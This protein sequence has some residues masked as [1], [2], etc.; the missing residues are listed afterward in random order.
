TGT[1]YS[2]PNPA[3]IGR[4]VDE[5]PSSVLAGHAWVGVQQGTICLSA[6]GK[7]PVFSGAAVI[8]MVSVGFCETRV[9]QQLL[10]ELPGYAVTLLLALALGAIG[11]LLLASRLKRQTFGLEPYEIAGLLEEREASLQGIH[12]GAIATD[13]D[14]IITLANDEGRRLLDLPADCVGRKISQ[15]LPQGRLL[16][17]LSGGLKDQDEV[18]LAGDRVLLASRRSIR[19]RG[20]EIGHVATLR[21]STEITGLARGLGVDSLTDALRAQ[22]HEFANRLHTIAG[23]VQLGRA[24]E[25]MKLIAQTSGLHQELT[26][27]LLDRVGDPVLGALLLAKAA[28]ASERGIELRVSDDTMITRSSLD[29]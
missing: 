20:Q 15:V 8:G 26:E 21:D 10:G 25:A 2:H 24:E 3:L 13:R 18:L 17:F 22:A 14:G 23:L 19:V 5:D 6:R 1:R 11:S 4:P 27:S 16:K 9:N 28:V 7:A 29:S 12:E